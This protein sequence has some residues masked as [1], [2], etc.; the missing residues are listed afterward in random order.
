MQRAVAS[1]VH[2]E[3]VANEERQQRLEVHGQRRHAAE[4][5]E[6][7]QHG[8]R[9]PRIAEALPEGRTDRW[10]GRGPWRS[11]QRIGPDEEHAGDHG[12]VAHGVD[13]E[14]AGDP[15]RRDRHPGDRGPDDARQVERRRAQRDGIDEILARHQ[16]RDERLPHRHLDGVHETGHQREQV[17]V[18]D[19]D[20]AG[21][22]EH[23]EGRGL[24]HRDAV[25]RDERATLVDAVGEDPTQRREEHRRPE[26][27]GHDEAQLER[28]ATQ[29]EHEP[30]QRHRLHPRAD[31]ASDLPEPV[32]P[33]VRMAHRREAPGDTPAA[34]SRNRRRPVGAASGTRQQWHHAA[35]MARWP[36]GEHSL[37]MLTKF[38]AAVERRNS[39]DEPRAIGHH[40]ATNRARM[41]ARAIP[42]R[43]VR[44]PRARRRRRTPLAALLL[45]LLA[46]AAPTLTLAPLQASE[47]L[48]AGPRPIDQLAPRPA[49]TLPQP[50]DAADLTDVLT[51]IV[52]PTPPAYVAPGPRFQE[53]LDAARAA[54]SAHGVTFAAVRDGE[55]VW[56]GASGR[57]RDGRTDLEPASPLVIGSVTKTFVAATVLQLVEE[58]RLRLDDPARRHLPEVAALGERIT[59]RQLLDHT[60]GLA[61]LFNDTTR[62]GLEEDVAHAWTADEIFETLHAPWYRPGEGWAYAN[63]NYYLLAMIAER[64]TGGRL[65]DELERRF[66][67]PLGLGTASVLDG[68]SVGSPLAAAWTTLFWGS[69][70]MAASAADLARWGDALYNGDV[71]SP[72]TRRAMLNVNDHDYGL[73]VQRIEIGSLTGYGHTGLLNTDTTLL[74]HLPQE[75]LTLALLVNRSHVDLAGMLRAEPADGPS[76]LELALDAS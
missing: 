35:Q 37:T 11:V 74:L 24:R 56:A 21:Q 54:A 59:V 1:R 34:D 28:R 46:F 9:A 62:R 7:P 65:A 66:L 71:L 40:G 69:G 33:I 70:A 13:A 76:L 23:E 55:L 63:T 73:G 68:T 48:A 44:R 8:R 5:D 29:L 52:Q 27:E 4:E 67:A 47:P 2:A 41:Q 26:H 36:K 57:A 42:V 30:R 61:D 20:H 19:L 72:T 25:D 14:V 75:R 31:Q 17:H 12:E 53:A 43:G 50:A 3:R 32:A 39:G 18:P 60:S 6:R 10:H 16:L 49:D 58:G 22:G 45:S 64:L 51:R 38:R 15:E